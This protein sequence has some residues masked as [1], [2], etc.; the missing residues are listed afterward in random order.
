MIFRMPF[1]FRLSEGFGRG[2]HNNRRLGAR[3]G[4]F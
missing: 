1:R 4:T 2:L 3:G